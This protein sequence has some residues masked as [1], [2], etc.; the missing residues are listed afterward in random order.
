MNS[1][2]K[3]QLCFGHCYGLNV[4]SKFVSRYLNSSVIIQDKAVKS[5]WVMRLFHTWVDIENLQK[6]RRDWIPSSAPLLCADFA[7]LPSGGCRNKASTTSKTGRWLSPPKKPSGDL[8]LGIQ[9]PKLGEVNFSCLCQFLMSPS[10]VLY[11][12]K[13][14]EQRKTTIKI[15][16]HSLYIT[17]LQRMRY[18]RV[19][20]F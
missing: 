20:N 12:R 1:L 13:I 9:T 17:L 16:L 8:I 11:Y 2:S 15:P 6:A 5:D 3:D 18:K 19:H 14:N 7:F 4:A 10:M